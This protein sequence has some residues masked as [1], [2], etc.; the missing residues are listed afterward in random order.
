[1]LKLETETLKKTVEE[2]S[3][4]RSTIKSR[5]WERA[6]D[7]KKLEERLLALEETAEPSS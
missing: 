5:A 1:M 6:P 3:R 2:L 4:E 7:A